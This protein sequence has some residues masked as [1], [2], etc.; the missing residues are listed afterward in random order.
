MTSSQNHIRYVCTTFDI[1]ITPNVLNI[2]YDDRSGAPAS[3]SGIRNAPPINPHHTDHQVFTTDHL[4]IMLFVGGGT[5]VTINDSRGRPS[6]RRTFNVPPALLGWVET[7]EGRQG[8]WLYV[9]DANRGSFAGM[10][11]F[12]PPSEFTPDHCS[13]SSMGHQF[14]VPAHDIDTL[15]TP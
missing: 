10:Y 12:I 14:A 5:V 7:N 13:G 11:S 4:S 2:A 15:S 3:F 9:N 6:R 8:H 1:E